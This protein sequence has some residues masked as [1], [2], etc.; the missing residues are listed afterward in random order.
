MTNHHIECGSSLCKLMDRL[1]RRGSR[2]IS[3][4]RSGEVLWSGNK[5]LAWN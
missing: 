5:V 1:D 2:N 3:T 4:S